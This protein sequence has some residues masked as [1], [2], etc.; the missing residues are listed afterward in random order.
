MK[1][2]I[3]VILV[4]SI[5]IS[6]AL[7]VC[8]AECNH[9]YIRTRVDATCF[10]KAHVMFSCQRCGHSYKIY[11]DEYTVPDGFHIVTKST[12]TDSTLTVTVE[13]FENP[14][15][16]AARLSMNYNTDAL[17]LKSVTF[18]N[19]WAK[20]DY[21]HSTDNTSPLKV[22]AIP[23][24]ESSHN[25]NNGVFFTAE[26]E[27]IQSTGYGI[28]FFHG[29]GDFPAWDNSTNT[30]V[31]HTPRIINLVG[32]EEYGEHSF[33]FC[34]AITESTFTE[35]GTALYVCTVCQAEKEDVLPLL[36]HWTKGDL[37]NDGKINAMDMNLII[38]LIVGMPGSLQILDAAD[39]N[40]DGRVNSMDA[41]MIRLAVS[42][43]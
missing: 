34:K 9:T 13:F 3:S 22:L 32:A 42:G 12:R 20:K 11:A 26:F 25:T 40:S 4:I 23:S 24:T 38:R 39:M 18:G 35:H 5:L 31:K 43:S 27:I 19:I 21:S 41:Y 10:E 15:I 29:A 37:N 2:L 36:E 8:A 7:S 30:T 17:T 28:S 14:G 16:D 6:A 33:E 1:K